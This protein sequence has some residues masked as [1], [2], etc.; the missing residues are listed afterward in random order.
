MNGTP[1]Q[2]IPEVARTTGL[3]TY[4][5]RRGVRDGTV[6]HIKSGT[7]YLVNVPALLRRLDVESTAQDRAVVPLQDQE[8]GAL[9]G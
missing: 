3:S 8:R 4:F 1:F 9:D 6:P 2:K 5:L 7:V